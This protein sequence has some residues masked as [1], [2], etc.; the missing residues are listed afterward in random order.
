[1]EISKKLLFKKYS[2]LNYYSKDVDDYINPK[3]YNRLLKEYT[4]NNLSDLEHFEKYI[5]SNV[6]KKNITALELGCGSGRVTDIFLKKITDF[7]QFDLVDLSQEM[8]E[9]SKKRFSKYNNLNF[10]SQDSI[11][12]LK[13]TNK[14][15]DFVF[16]L[17]SL[18]HSIH[19]HMSKEGVEKASASIR[20]ILINFI[21]NKLAKNAVFFLI[22]FDSLS[23][24]QRI[25]KRQEA[26]SSPVYIE[27]NKQSHSKRLIDDVFKFLSKKKIIK[28]TCKHYIG[29][30]IK[31]KSI[32]EA[33][34]TF[35]NFHMET[36]FNRSDDLGEIIN[37]IIKDFE[38]YRRGPKVYISPRCFIYT[39]KKVK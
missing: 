3:Y 30:T 37:E 4:F 25:V 23:D 31:Y 36:Y 38:P 33:L 20:K 17:W 32:N 16:S 18:S 9:F 10:F 27:T 22:H 26:K 39:F 29:K 12:F 21:K 28:F 2:W 1:M 11:N 7:K 14:K 6:N 8:I 35:M 5:Y 24:E 13:K 15:Y 34:E 19:D